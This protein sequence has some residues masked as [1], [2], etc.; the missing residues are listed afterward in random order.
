MRFRVAALEGA[1]S[2]AR[3]ENFRWIRA[4][5]RVAGDRLAAFDAFEQERIFRV[6]GDAQIG[7]DGR[8]QIGGVGFVDG[9]EI[10]LAARA[11]R[12]F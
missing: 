5:K 2:T 3:A 10:A 6:A 1:G 11:S 9:H 8:Q 12:M 4:G 7:A